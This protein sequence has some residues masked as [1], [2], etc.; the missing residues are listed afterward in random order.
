[1]VKRKLLP[2]LLVSAVLVAAAAGS[3]FG[4]FTIE[5]GEIFVLS[6]GEILTIDG[7]TE[8]WDKDQT[9]ATTYDNDI[10]GIGRDD[11]SELNQKQ[12]KLVNSD[13][14]VAMGL[15]E[16]ATDNASNPNTFAADLRFMTWGNNGGAATW[17][18][19]G[20]PAHSGCR[21]VSRIWSVQETGDVG[22]VK[23]EFDV[24]DADF[25]LPAQKA[26]TGYFFVYDTDNDGTLTDELIVQMFDDG[27]RGGD[28]TASDNIWTV[29]NINLENGQEF[30]IVN[31][32]LRRIIVVE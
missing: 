28:E 2:I 14:I 24:A 16:I 11:D 17:T 26:G 12:S 4:D 5:S 9:D 30:T 21:I 7:N 6:N 3:V 19:T 10:A 15:R 23:I 1:M 20:A 22:T 18:N 27:S 29:N 31:M 8:M 13:A 25:D 32:M